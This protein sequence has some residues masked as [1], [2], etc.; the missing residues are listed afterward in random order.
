MPLELISIELTN[1]CAK[2]CRFCYNHSRPD[3]ETRWTADEVVDFVRDCAGNGVKSASF[4][5]GEPLQYEGL[6]EILKN[7][8]GVLFRSVTTNGLLLCGHTLD[9][10]VAARPDKA[11]VSIH[12]PERPEE[13]DR[14]VGQVVELSRRGIRSGVNLLVA[15]SKLGAA[16][17]AA[18]RLRGAGIGNERIVYLPMRGD[19]TPAPEEIADVAGRMPFQSMTC[20]T[21]CGPS[22]RFAS[23]GWDRTVAW[24]SYTESRRPLEELTFRGLS[25]TLDGLGLT[26]CGGAHDVAGSIR[27][28]LAVV[29]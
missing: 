29:A 11:H 25:N 28:P 12:F 26:F 10:F 21:Q 13:V 22:P 24:C 3:G 18:E 6:F 23:I 14:V 8:D 19:D 20:L 27:R 9:E 7:L 4:G 16:R 17:K 15:K 2:A 1:R 5:G